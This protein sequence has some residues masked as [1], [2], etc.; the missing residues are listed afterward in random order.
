MPASLKRCLSDVS[1]IIVRATNSGERAWRE[2]YLK[3]VSMTCLFLVILKYIIRIFMCLFICVSFIC[4]KIKTKIFKYIF[5]QFISFYFYPKISIT[6]KLLF[7]YLFFSSN[8][9]NEIIF[10][11][12]IAQNRL[13]PLQTQE[14]FR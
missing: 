3:C 6:R 14:V 2:E 11:I 8:T 7:Y 10:K 12:W 13:S 4:W 9:E 5:Y 1:M